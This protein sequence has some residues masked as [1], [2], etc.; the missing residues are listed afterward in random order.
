VAT[1]ILPRVIQPDRGGPA[2]LA[3]VTV[4]AALPW[5]SAMAHAVRAGSFEWEDLFIA[6]V[7]LWLILPTMFVAVAELPRRRWLST[8]V[9]FAATSLVLFVALAVAVRNVSSDPQPLGSM[10][11]S[12]AG[13]WAVLLASAV[14]FAALCVVAEPVFRFLA[15]RGAL[16]RA[17]EVQESWRKAFVAGMASCA[18]VGPAVWV[19]WRDGAATAAVSTFVVGLNVVAWVLR[20]CPA[21]QVCKWVVVL[22]IPALVALLAGPTTT[23]LWILVVGLAYAAALGVLCSRSA[24]AVD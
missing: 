14:G 18:L 4:Y 7:A 5:I 22:A 8:A 19:I 6:G 10:V 24:V 13:A 20:R 9:W 11:V 3:A 1:E 2:A 21:D 23:A 12:F 16:K 17:D 15:G